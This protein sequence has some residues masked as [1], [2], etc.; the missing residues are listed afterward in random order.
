MQPNGSQDTY[1]ATPT[2]TCNSAAFAADKALGAK[3]AAGFVLASFPAAADLLRHFLAG[4]GTPVGYGA[5]SPVSRK[6]RAS[7]VFRSMNSGVQE[8]ILSQLRTGKTRVE[9]PAVQLPAVAF[10]SKT[11]DLYWGFRGTQG[12]TLT[13]RG[14]RENG[15]FVG[16]L[17]Y[18]IRDSYGFPATDALGGIGTRMRY[19]QT[20]CGAPQHPGGARWFPDSITVTVPFSRRS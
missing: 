7:S 14:S 15:R 19:L 9:L 17:T 5:G 1:A 20:V 13:G 18:V 3:V 11:S 8:A 4:H 16:T 12:V 6:A 10:E 2:A